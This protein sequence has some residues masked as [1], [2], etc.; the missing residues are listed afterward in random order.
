M[1][2]LEPVPLSKHSLVFEFQQNGFYSFFLLNRVF[3]N[4]PG[5]KVI[6]LFF[7]IADASEK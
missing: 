5:A 2:M 1:S 3:T 4:V 6:K 7:F